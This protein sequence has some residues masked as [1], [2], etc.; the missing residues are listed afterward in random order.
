MDAAWASG[1]RWVTGPPY[2]TGTSGTPVV[3]FTTQPLYFTDPGDLSASVN[4]AAANALV[5]AAVGAWNVRTSAMVVAYG[6]A[7]AEHV[8][9]ANSYL[10][11]TGPVFPVDVQSS[12]YAAKQIAVIYDS[13]GSVTDMLLG[14]S[15]SDPAEC[16]QNGVT[17]SVDS[18]VPAGLIQHAILVLN[19]RCTGPAPEQQLQMQYQLER[20]FG[21]VLGLG[22][23]QT[24]DNVFT[25]TP[26]PTVAQAQHWP[27]LH[28]IDIVC[29]AYT[30]QCLP[31]PFTLRDDDVAAI[32]S[33]YPYVTNY[34]PSI[35]P[36]APGKTWSYVQASIV[37]GTL[38]FPTGQGMQG[39]NIVLQRQQGGWNIPE[40]WYDVS[41]VTG[42]VFQQNAGNPV[43]GPSSGM[44]GSMGTTD[45]QLEGAYTFSWVPD[46]DPEGAQNGG[47]FI[48]LTTEAIN[49]L[50]IGTHS[51]GPYTI[52]NVEPSGA[53]MSQKQDTNPTLP[54]WASWDALPTAFPANNAASNCNT[55]GDGVESSPLPVAASGWWTDVLCAHGHN[56]WSSLAA[57][58]GRTATIE[59]TALDETGVATTAKAMPQIGVWAATDSTG[60]LP[61]VAATPSAFNT[62][63][64]GMT[65]TG[66]ATT[67]AE[68]LRFVI[69]DARGDGRPDFAYQA[70]V[71]YADTIQPAVTSVNGGQITITGL[72][73]RAGNEV[74]VNGVAAVVS[75]WSA[76]TIVAVA[77]LES[78]FPT[79]PAGPVDVEVIDLSTG[80]STVMTGALTYGNVAP[81]EMMLVSAPSGTVVVGVAAAVP[82][83]VRVVLGDGVTPVAGLPVTFSVIAGSAQ[84]GACAAT[85]C[86]VLT[87]ATG[88]AATTMTA[89]AFGIVTVQAAA[90]GAVQ[91][92][93]FQAVVRSVTVTQPVEYIA[94]GAIVE[95]TPQVSVLQNGAPAAGVVVVWIASG[96]MTVSSGSSLVNALG[97]AQVAAIAGPL[98]AGAQATGQACAWVTVCANF[99]AVGVDPSA[100]RLAIVSG[101][102]QTVPATAT[103]A[104]VVAMVTDGSGDPVAGAPVAIY[105]TVEAAEMPCPVRGSCPIAPL[106]GASSSTAV[107]D[108][109]GL[110]SVVP[111]QVAGAGEVTKLAVAAGTQG[112]ASLSLAQ[113]P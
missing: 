28:P 101:A 44:S 73:F 98:A 9:G 63:T 69:A 93:T 54:Y 51:V 52:G 25:R 23:S 94:A 84:F 90:V 5:A 55:G 88:M 14:G 111:M 65:A 89:T 87:D 16:R 15:A 27:I 3:W 32:T 38:T 41:T 60:T 30:Y 31:Q 95:W 61:T 1:P 56:A 42:S 37:Y 21:R 85:P 79:P 24:N 2:F 67:Q 11:A 46:I 113:Q 100:W 26:Q 99:A 22:W 33:L 43:N 48:V 50:Y 64:L 57:Q 58:A 34:S 105:Q 18:I 45:L 104:L 10:S 7:L 35:P 103:F 112:F 47:M 102:G 59:V 62:I 82:F 74:T 110:V 81:D 106:I 6:G 71:L 108:D 80:G 49:P 68:G 40:A 29:G 109:D 20:A 78:A 77:P 8:S 86:M 92:A 70:R 4:H 72:G 12:N 76:T 107:S 96:G 17:E 13:D 91:T 19:G 53:P 83:A 97:I 66:L 36:P 75:S 39:V